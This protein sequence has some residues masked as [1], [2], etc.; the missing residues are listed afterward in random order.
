ME[1]RLF[2]RLTESSVEFVADTVLGEDSAVVEFVGDFEGRPV[3]WR[4]TIIALKATIS[5]AQHGQ[6]TVQYI[7]VSADQRPK[8]KLTTV[9]VG[10]FVSQVDEPTVLKV[11][12]MIRQYR[13]LRRGRHE[14]AGTKK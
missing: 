6:P 2:K 12:K 8:D 9:E 10:L 3:I 11:I 1:I 5:A 13:N 7:D 14:F 4:A